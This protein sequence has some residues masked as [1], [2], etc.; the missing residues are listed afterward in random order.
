MSEFPPENTERQTSNV[1]YVYRYYADS[2]CS[3]WLPSISAFPAILRDVAFSVDG[4]NGYIV[5]RH[6]AILRTRNGGASW[7]PLTRGA[8]HPAQALSAAPEGGSYW[9][10]P[11]PWTYVP[12][13]LFL[14]SLAAAIVISAV[15]EANSL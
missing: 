8:L 5:G 7:Q 13:V 11:P 3:R 12:L 1:V 10:L 2:G 4:S 15:P 6:G 9:R 14:G